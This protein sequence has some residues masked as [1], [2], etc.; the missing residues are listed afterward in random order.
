MVTYDVTNSRWSYNYIILVIPYSILGTT[1]NMTHE[2][3]NRIVITPVRFWTKAW[4]HVGE[5]IL[6]KAR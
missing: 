6:Q 4:S 1:N 5:V 2:I 3:T